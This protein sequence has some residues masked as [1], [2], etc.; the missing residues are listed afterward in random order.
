MRSIG[1]IVFCLLC[2]VTILIMPVCANP[3]MSVHMKY[4]FSEDNEPVTGS[5]NFTINCYGFS[6]NDN[7]NTSIIQNSTNKS[8]EPQLLYSDSTNCIFGVNSSDQND[9]E[10]KQTYTWY[11][12]Q[13]SGKK[14]LYCDLVGAYNAK[15]FKI[16]NFTTAL[17]SF[18]VYYGPD[19]YTSQYQSKEQYYFLST[20]DANY[21]FDRYLTKNDPCKINKRYFTP[22]ELDRCQKNA[23]LE[24]QTC[25]RLYG[26]PI[27][28]ADNHFD[29]YPYLCE[30][31]FNLSS[32]NQTPVLTPVSNMSPSNNQ[33]HLATLYCGLMNLLGAKC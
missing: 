12:N 17:D 21:C 9:C 14:I 22:D 3:I 7:Q 8:D 13:I 23:A 29:L 4:N 26:H 33:S 32:N 19:Y 2:M 15:P 5:V 27:T 30:F 25:Y 18:C 10:K 28:V 31:Q 1:I 24:H 20:K 11:R 6:Q 16:N